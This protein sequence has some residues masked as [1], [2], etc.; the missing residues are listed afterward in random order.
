ML[1]CTCKS[2]TINFTYSSLDTVVGEKAF[3]FDDDSICIYDHPFRNSCCTFSSHIHVCAFE[4]E[5]LGKKESIFLQRWKN[6]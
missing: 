4:K 2:Y 1:L 3:N 5:I 6:I